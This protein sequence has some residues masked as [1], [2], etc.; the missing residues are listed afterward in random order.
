MPLTPADD[1]MP[2]RVPLNTASLFPYAA[3]PLLN[4]TSES[5]ALPVNPTLLFIEQFYHPEG[6]GGAELPRSLTM[7]LARNGFGVEVICG[8]D[9]YAP[10]DGEGGEDPRTAGVKVRR[11][12]AIR[13][14]AV[15]HAKA[16]RQA[17]FVVAGSAMLLFRSRPAL[18]VAQTNPPMGVIL[19]AI[20]ARIWRRPLVIVAMDIY[21]DVL[22]AHGALASGSIAAKVLGRIFCWAYRSAARV[23]AL[24]PVMRQKLVAKGVRDIRIVEIPN[25][26]TG[27]PGIVRGTANAL[28]REWNLEGRFV[29]AYSGNIGIAH[30]FETVLEGFSQALVSKPE[31]LLVIIGKGTRLGEV[32]ATVERLGLHGSVLFKPFLPASRLPES[33]GIADLALV[34][35]RTGFEGLVVPSK[36]YGYLSRGVPV[37]YVGPHSDTEIAIQHAGCG[38]ILR[39]GDS[40][41][42]C[43]ALLALQADASLRQRLG[44]SGRLVYEA[45]WSPAH[46]LARYES[47]LRALVPGPWAK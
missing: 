13:R 26:S 1:S 21:P 9:Q 35:L 38:V 32:R 43:E 42:V 46:A 27:N 37:L 8:S 17:W 11:V 10:V 12:P 5:L 39:N 34:T 29:I 20:A 15:K 4:C 24:G 40:R 18:V 22:V 7:H 3:P 23:V 16:I 14:L 28:L 41:G 25:W 47:M 44:V 36:L 19:A 2:V 45:E 6:W 33:F 30:E 31:M